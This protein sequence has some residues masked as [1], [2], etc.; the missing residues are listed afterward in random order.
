MLWLDVVAE[1]LVGPGRYVAGLETQSAMLGVK[2]YLTDAKIDYSDASR[3]A[4]CD[5]GSDFVHGPA[6]S[7]L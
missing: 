1:V 5:C 4:F 7:D 3:T 2:S 6:C